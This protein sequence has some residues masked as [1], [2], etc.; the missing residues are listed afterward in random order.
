LL[1]TIPATLVRDINTVDSYP[2]E[3]T[4]A[5][6][7]L[8]YTVDGSAATG[9]E[10]AVTAAGGGTQLLKD[11]VPGQATANPS[12]PNDPPTGPENLTA[13]GNSV[14]F[15]ASEGTSQDLLWTS[16]GT[17]VQPVSF[18]DP[19]QT[20]STVVSGLTAVSDTLFF[21]SRVPGSAM[22]QTSYGPDLWSIAPGGQPVLDAA[23]LTSDQSGVS[24]FAAIGGLLY[25]TVSS[26][27]AQQELWSSDG[28]PGGTL[29]FSFTDPTTHQSTNITDVDQI[30]SVNGSLY[31]ETSTSGLALDYFNGTQPVTLAT[32][33]SGDGPSNFTVAGANLF[34]DASD[35]TNGRE[36][37]VSNGTAQGTALV[38]D[39]L[40]GS[41]GSYPANLTDVNGT[42]Y[43]TA[44]GPN[45]SDQLWKSD[46]TAQGTTLVTDLAG[47]PSGA[48]GYYG[49]G[50][51]YGPR[52]SAAP[53]LEAL[54][55]TL[56]F[57]NSDA[58]HGNELW[59]TSASSAPAL[60][61]DIDPGAASS[62]PH[63]FVDFNGQLYFAAHDGTTPQVNQLWQSDGV[64]TQLVES[65]SPSAT[66]GSY[67]SNDFATIG[68]DVLFVANDGIDGPEL[69]VTD[70][71]TAGTSLVAAVDPTAFGTMGG[72][73]YFLATSHN[74]SALWKTDGTAGG[75][76][77]V[78]NLPSATSSYNA[79][80]QDL[81]VAGGKLYFVS[82]DGTSN[83]EDLWVVS[84]GAASVVQDFTI[85]SG[86]SGP[87]TPELA[88]L[89]S[90][91][92]L[93][94]F[95]ANDGTHG[96]QLWVSDGTPGATQ[97]V[98]DINPG[99]AGGNPADLTPVGNQVYF[100]AY[101][102]Q[103]KVG[104]WVRSGTSGDA[105]VVKDDFPSA[106]FPVPNPA[107]GQPATQTVT[108]SISSL[109]A[110]GTTLFFSLVYRPTESSGTIS[111]Q[112]NLWTSN[113]TY[114]GTSQVNAPAAGAFQHLDTLIP[115]GNLLVFVANDGTHGNELWRSDGTSTGTFLLKDI[116]PGAG[117]SIPNYGFYNQQPVI[118]NGF[119][120]FAA[121]DGTGGEELWQ[122]DGTTAN[123]QLVADTDPGGGSSAPQPLTV[124]D[125]RLFLF[126]S[127]GAHGQELMTIAS[128][129]SPVIGQ[130]PRESVTQGQT[131][132][133]N[134]GGFASDASVPQ[135][136][137]TYSLGAGAPSG[138]SINPSTG[139][140]SWSPSLSVPVATY[141]ITVIA[142]DGHATP[143]STSQT[144]NISVLYG[145]PPPTIVK[146]TLTTKKVFTITLTFSQALESGPATNA[147][148]Y[149][150]I[151]P[152]KYK[153][154]KNKLIRL[155]PNYVAGSTVVTLTTKAKVRFSPALQFTVF[156]SAPGGLA[157]IY[158]TLLGGSSGQAGSNYLATV[159]KRGLIQ[160]A[161][162]PV[163][164]GKINARTA[165]S[166]ILARS[167][168]LPA[169]PLHHIRAA[170]H[171]RLP[172]ARL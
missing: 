3:L 37:W 123:T 135:Q 39:I 133:L 61:G 164:K 32:F 5:G 137:L 6:T 100:I 149:Q 13:V 130:L 158:G 64:T 113:G 148:N 65:F 83:G 89:T 138:A 129:V 45:D 141:T 75:T 121:A 106:T 97:M 38:K 36:L 12:Y 90:A 82:S 109:A 52:T 68:T 153:R 15:L 4:P 27:A 23:N 163:A 128:E 112:Y 94:Y 55:G 14:Y 143:L 58:A 156:G 29:L 28:T 20:Q 161:S 171:V 103:N 101:E 92:G 19:N 147:N 78:Q 62:A 160:V 102:A 119:L 67:V 96:D 122:T 111:D 167:R 144:F 85:P 59:S 114:S 93:L 125:G 152:P 21:I 30:A 24:H 105:V 127:D 98:S 157:N 150:L 8:F 154:G 74:T 116:N 126:A 159:T 11:F 170:H 50:Y 72:T 134:V 66:Q 48:R 115:L 162:F 107:P 108:P 18:S 16:D 60:V 35:P 43:F 84:G 2:A 151:V 142:S 33:Q 124:V 81:V 25:F 80:G 51:N 87:S 57:A 169:G 117:D 172:R 110:V 86:S 9:I 22:N 1:S 47:Q 41:K 40:P 31:Y 120:Y 99:P 53:V 168:D 44:T 88:N 165:S 118:A 34:F 17:A 63:D 91:G 95:T 42:L 140:F 54:G 104:L 76:S 73:V 131:I 46:G 49:Y 79:Y 136:A 155:S 10:L 69:W 146:A 77:V 166:P 56:F 70:G 139:L 7:N 71:T 145:G 132:A 26:G